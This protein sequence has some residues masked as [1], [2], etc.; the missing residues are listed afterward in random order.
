MKLED[1]TTI[2]ECFLWADEQWPG[3]WDATTT[4][5]KKP[6]PEFLQAFES[7]DEIQGTP[8]FEEFLEHFSKVAKKDRSPLA[9]QLLYQG[10]TSK[11]R[12]YP[13]K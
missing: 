9:I 6:T 1:C 5:G 4:F 12:N 2:L 10:A 3:F 13:E 8:S 7:E 11:K